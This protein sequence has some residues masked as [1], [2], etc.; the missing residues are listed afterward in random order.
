[1]INLI[2]KNWIWR[3]VNSFGIPGKSIRVKVKTSRG[4][5]VVE[6]SA[7]RYVAEHIPRLNELLHP[8]DAHTGSVSASQAPRVYIK[9]TPALLQTF[10]AVKQILQNPSVLSHFVPTRPLYL[11]TDASNTGYGAVLFQIDKEPLKTAQV[12]PLAYSSQAWKTTSER[13]AHPCRKELDALKRVILKYHYLLRIYPFMIITD[14][15]DVFHLVQNFAQGKPPTDLILVRYL[16]SICLHPIL[17][18]M[19]KPSRQVFTSDAL[20]RMAWQQL[21]ISSDDPIAW[22]TLFIAPSLMEAISRQIT[23]HCAIPNVNTA[24][25]ANTLSTNACVPCVLA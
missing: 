8:F 2:D 5:V 1:M 15:M 17:G 14:N 4:R 22:P 23:R 20:S 3:R 9:W 24:S 6:T 7:L 19:H 21:A 11:E 25:K 12:F 13:A 16:Q 10:D 18:I